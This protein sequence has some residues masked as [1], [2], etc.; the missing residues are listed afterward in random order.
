[1]ESDLLKNLKSAEIMGSKRIMY[2]STCD[3]ICD[4]FGNDCPGRDAMELKL[5][6]YKVSE[7]K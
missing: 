1:M 4:D 6:P 3:N 5:K 2:S 7:K